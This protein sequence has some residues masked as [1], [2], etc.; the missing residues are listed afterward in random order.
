M[1]PGSSPPTAA[2]RALVVA[3][4]ALPPLLL[5]G[6][7]IRHPHVLT[8][9]TATWWRDLHV[10]GLVLFPLLAVPPWLVVR[11]KGRAIEVTMLVL[12]LVYAAF[13][14]A[15]DAIAG[16]GGGAA[17]L[18]VGPGPWVSSLFGVADQVVLPG[19]YAHL[20]AAVLAAVVVVA[21]TRGL[22]L[23]AAVVGGVLV[24]GAAYEFVTS[25]I[26]YPYG[27]AAMVGL[28]VGWA[29]LALAATAPDRRTGAGT[30]DRRPEPAARHGR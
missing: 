30:V 2:R 21:T 27:V 8:P 28:A 23:V 20:A 10:I 18:A 11:G 7:G 16:I 22:A 4:A 5:A 6:V 12:G 24:V 19:V 17:T 1:R 14:T 13:Y 9:E 26:Y 29:L 25:H 3:G 15:L